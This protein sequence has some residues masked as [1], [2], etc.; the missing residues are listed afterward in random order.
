MVTLVFGWVCGVGIC[1]SCRVALN[2]AGALL[3]WFGWCS[4]C[5]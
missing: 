1:V 4:L 5:F 3:V 2:I